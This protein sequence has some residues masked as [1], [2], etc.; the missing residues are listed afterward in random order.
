MVTS[1]A[2]TP[3]EDKIAER[4]GESMRRFEFDLLCV[5]VL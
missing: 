1:M 4:F 5:V 3:T 2:K